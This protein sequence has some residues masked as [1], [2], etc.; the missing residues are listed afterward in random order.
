MR[1]TVFPASAILV[2]LLAGVSAHEGDSL[3]QA[4]KSFHDVLAGLVHG[5]A[6]KGDFAP[7]RAQAEEFARL[8]TGIM[9]A[10]LPPKLA[11]RC[12][13]ISTRAQELSR[14][15]DSLAMRAKEKAPDAAVR[16]AFESVHVAYRNLNGA[17]ASLEDL[18]QAFHD[19]LHPLWHDAYPNKNAAAIKAE[20]PKL[21]VRAKLI[22]STA[23]GADQAKVPGAR[24]LLDAVTTLDEA[25][26]AKDD[27]AVLEALRIVHEA[28]EKLAEGH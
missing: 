22:L 27:M 20:T 2:L 26:A 28:Y 13:E 23:E 7:V 9:A 14:A 25:V 16:A 21:K 10:S 15:V 11:K 4:L 3:K 8:R 24:S 6:E 5:P 18:F 19:V 12:P 17:M 1:R